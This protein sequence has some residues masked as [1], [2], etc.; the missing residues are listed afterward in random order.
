MSIENETKDMKLTAKASP[1]EIAA[2]AIYGGGNGIFNYMLNSFGNYF[3]TNVV[4]I[5][6]MVTGFFMTIC[7]IID[8][9]TDLLM[10]TLIDKGQNKSGEKARPWL[11]RA[12]IPGSIGLI[13][14]FSA[15]FATERASLIWAIATYFI[16]T[17]ICFTMNIIPYQTMMPLISGERVSRTKL[18]ASY[19]IIAMAISLVAG[20]C[21]EPLATALGGGRK[22]WLM[23][24][25][26]L[27]VVAL[28]LHLIGYLGTKEHVR[29]DSPVTEKISY[30]EVLKQ[31]GL[32]LKNKYWVLIALFTII[33]S[34][35]TMSAAMMYYVQYVMG[36]FSV[37]AYVMVVMMVPPMV[38]MAIAPMIVAKFGKGTVIRF[39]SLAMLV[40]AIIVWSS[41]T[42]SAFYIGVILLAFGQ[43]GATATMISFLGDSIDYGEYKFG[44]RTDGVGVSLNV[45]LQKI[46]Q[47]CAS[48]LLGAILTVG[49][50]DANA[51]EQTA[52]SV[53]A[54]K[55][56]FCGVPILIAVGLFI[57]SI[58]MNIEKKY[59]D[60]PEELAK[61]RLERSANK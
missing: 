6:A 58:F 45:S 13:L 43:G 39:G 15:P 38:M 33:N 30:T 11:K 5:N 52:S 25:C 47:A 42:A 27:A 21:V 8:F 20:I 55:I 50:Y 57:I 19:G 35:S 24:A 26:I 16:A 49:G 34:L 7:K 41:A 31:I 29:I 51:F 23:T 17:S 48:L 22:G 3:Y 53:T 37:L 46:A 44:V 32:L 10:G 14:M 1:K 2:F 56:A 40:G 61:M 54:I 60:L 12:M 9:L 36:D 4:G 28:I 59:P 18:E